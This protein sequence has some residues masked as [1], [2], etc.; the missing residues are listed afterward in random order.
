MI[1]S[2]GRSFLGQINCH[3]S[4][5]VTLTGVTATD[6]ACSR[7]L[8]WWSKR[9]L[10]RQTQFGAANGP[11]GTWILW[12]RKKAVTRSHCGPGAVARQ[13]TSRH[14]SNCVSENMIPYFRFTFGGFHIWR[15]QSVGTGGRGPQKADKRNKISWFVTLT[16]G[17]GVK[18]SQN[19]ADVLYGSPLPTN[20]TKLGKKYRQVLLTHATHPSPNSQLNPFRCFGSS[21]PPRSRCPCPTSPVR[22]DWKKRSTLLDRMDGNV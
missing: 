4:R 6:G 7:F 17:E 20:T 14:F 15:P 16:R 13:G 2:R 1:Y 12:E 8:W 5:I 3:C 21:T 18:K 22:F 11:F 10:A 19:F 9:R